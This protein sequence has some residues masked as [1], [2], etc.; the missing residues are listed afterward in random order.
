MAWARVSA[1]DPV[2]PLNSSARPGSG[3]AVASSR[4]AESRTLW[5]TAWPAL[6]PPRPSGWSFPSG[7]RDREGFSPN[8]PQFEA[9]IRIDPPLSVAWAAGTTPIATATAEP[10]LEPPALRVGSKGF[11]V[12]P[13]IAGAVH[14]FR[15]N[16]G[17]LVFPRRTSPA[18][19]RRP[20][21]TESCWGTKP[22]RAR[23]PLVAAIPRTQV[24][25]SLTRNGTPTSGP[26]NWPAST[27]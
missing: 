18:A 16:S 23:L 21:S 22:A 26:T 17:V 11:G 7:T 2:D 27:S 19:R 14:T 24:F 6:S 8:N 15:P 4:T 25:R 10:P 20:T 12:T 1:N 9:G 5:V 3:P 13:N